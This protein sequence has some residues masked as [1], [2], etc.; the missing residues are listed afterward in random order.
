MLYLSVRCSHLGNT[1]FHRGDFY[2]VLSGECRLNEQLRR[3]I[4]ASCRLPQS[5][6]DA[7]V[8]WLVQT[9]TVASEV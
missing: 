4:L 3:Y 5:D 2:Q 8:T 9:V 1:T 6:I 7:L